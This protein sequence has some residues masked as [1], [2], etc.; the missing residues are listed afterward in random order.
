MGT[1]LYRLL[2]ACALDRGTYEGIEADRRPVVTFEAFVTV[3]LSSL[4]AG[5]GGTG[6]LGRQ[7][8]VFGGLTA[9]ALVTW[10]AWAVLMLQ[11]GTRIMPDRE[12]QSDLGELLRTTG[13]AAAPGFLQVFAVLPGIP[14]AI[15]A[16]TWIWMLVAMVVAVRQVLD[17][18]SV[19][20]AIAVCGVA[21][22]ISI[23]MAVMIAVLLVRTA[24]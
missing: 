3:V 16:A 24:Y 7:A 18:R 8:T 13:F 11:I 1:Y 12:T 17:F 21:A 2:G 5:L 20:R 19:G 23:L 6:I 10:I 15:F 9:L 22:L 4:A 14:R